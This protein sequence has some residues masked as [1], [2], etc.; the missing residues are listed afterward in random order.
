MNV[1]VPKFECIL[2]NVYKKQM[3]RVRDQFKESAY[4]LSL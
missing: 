3:Q 2:G 4:K 1:R